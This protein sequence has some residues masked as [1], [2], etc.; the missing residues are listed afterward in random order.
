MMD[1]FELM[2]SDLDATWKQNEILIDQIFEATLKHDIK[3]CVLMCNDFVNN[4]S[5]DEME[6]V[7]RE[8]IDVQD[9]LHKR[10]KILEYAVQREVKAM[11]D[12]FELVESDLDA[13][14]KQNEILIDQIFEATLKHDI[15]HYVLMCNDFVN[16][17][18]LD[19][20]EKVKR[21]SIDVQDNLHKRIKILE[22]AVQRCQ[23][24]SLHFELQLQH[25]NEKKIMN[26]L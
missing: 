3:H 16:N 7:K 2:E 21:E 4:N 6:K 1:V 24:Q 22:Y 25:Q 15:K 9:N 26:L 8:S 17:N 5:L 13:T 11:M 23:K 18:S 12:V 20:M 10:I 14:W 19:E